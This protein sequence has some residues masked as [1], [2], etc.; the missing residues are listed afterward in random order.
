M[1]MKFHGNVRG[2]V[3]VSFLAPLVS[4]PHI[5]WVHAN[6]GIINGGVACICAKW[7]AFMHFC[8]VLRF[9]VRFCAFFFCQNGQQ[10]S[11]NLHIIVQKCAKTAFMQ[12]PLWLYPLLRVTEF[13]CAVPSN[14]SGI[15]RAN[16][17]LSIAI[18]ML[19][20]LSL[21]KVGIGIDIELQKS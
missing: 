11:A 21:I 9:F 18:P 1:L 13:S 19:F 17:R 8:A 6:G 3:R 2:E 14:L 16:V 4:K 10:K 5:F 7:C 12:Y 20:L 15:V